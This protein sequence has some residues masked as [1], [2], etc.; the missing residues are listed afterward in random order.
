MLK[1]LW[2]IF[3]FSFLTMTVSHCIPRRTTP[4]G[5][6]KAASAVE[7]ATADDTEYKVDDKN[8]LMKR[9]KDGNWVVVDKD[10]KSFQKSKNGDVFIVT[11]NK[12]LKMIR[13]GVTTPR[14]DFGDKAVLM[15][16]DS[17]EPSAA[18]MALGD[19][20]PP[21]Q[22]YLPDDLTEYK[23]GSD[24]VLLKKGDGERDWSVFTYVQMQHFPGNMASVS[25]HGLESYVNPYKTEYKFEKKILTIEGILIDDRDSSLLKKL[26][27]AS[28]FTYLDANDPWYN[29][30]NS[31]T[32]LVPHQ[33]HSIERLVNVLSFYRAPN[34][35]LYVL[36][37][38]HTMTLIRHGFALAQFYTGL[39]SLNM[40]EDGTAYWLPWNHWQVDNWSPKKTRVLPP[41]KERSFCERDPSPAMVMK[42]AHM[43]SIDQYFEPGPGESASQGVAPDN[44]SPFRNVQIVVEPMVDRLDEVRTF[45][46]I[47]LGRSHQCQYKTTILYL[48]KADA[49]VRDHVIYIGV[50]DVI[51]QTAASGGAAVAASSVGDY[52]SQSLGHSEK[53]KLA[54]FRDSM[55][56]STGSDGVIYKL[57]VRDE[58][59]LGSLS[60]GTE[61]PPR[62]LWRLPRGATW[63][64]EGR[65]YSFAE[66]SEGTL[67]VLNAKNELK[68]LAK[69]ANQWK[70]VDSKLQAFAMSPNGILYTL[71]SNGL[72]RMMAP[73]SNKWAVLDRGVESFLMAPDG[74]LTELNSRRQLRR[75]AGGTRWSMLDTGVQSV[76]WA[77]DGIVYELNNRRQLKRLSVSGVWTTLDTGVMSFRRDLEGVL[78]ALNT[79]YQ[80]KQLTQVEWEYLGDIW[81]LKKQKYSL[82]W[83]IVASNVQ[84]FVVAPSQF[85]DVYVLSRSKVL[86]RLEAGVWMELKTGIKS[87]MMES[88]GLVRAVD[89]RNTSWLFAPTY[90][91][92]IRDP[93][94]VEVGDP[95]EG[96]VFCGPEHFPTAEEI[97]KA[98]HVTPGVG[99]SVVSAPLIDQLDSWKLFPTEGPA[100]H[101]DPTAIYPFTDHPAKNHRCHYQSTINFEPPL[102]RKSM[103]IYVDRDVVIRWGFKPDVLRSLGWES[104]DPTNSSV[105]DQRWMK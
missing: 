5:A 21:P 29:I 70:L 44:K 2:T 65:V 28:Q 7:P 3:S 61:P 66:S 22:E 97:L 103:N 23:I 74:T 30:F 64:Y 17:A 52:G 62:E 76:E 85:N 102:K 72:L 45:P 57:G 77:P 31:G 81:A 12:K 96:D 69:G 54:I 33:G 34:G 93:V 63:Q 75:F 60:N 86:T 105:V 89:L 27:G 8:Q 38:Q 82:S 41:Q 15:L 50:N 73:G 4:S 11:T 46:G 37:N 71:N 94:Y 19:V 35:Y 101:V 91:A 9:D 16:N 56:V 39:K 1:T 24:G 18:T 47:G 51:R 20:E 95:V 49:E 78:Y 90:M 25:E 99:I 55:S 59:K 42:A 13:N 83:K 92:E 10:V 100:D 98:G 87:L 40:D 43:T 80:L 68:S 14:G 84:T 104:P 79:Q 67:F 26:P 32:H 6:S 58:W 88:D 48:T 36:T 53:K